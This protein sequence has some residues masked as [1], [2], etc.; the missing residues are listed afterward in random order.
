MGGYILGDKSMASAWVESRQ[1]IWNVTSAK[2]EV[3]PS[4]RRKLEIISY[5][6]LHGLNIFVHRTKWR[7]HK[8][9][10]KS[11]YSNW[12]VEIEKSLL[13]FVW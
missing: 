4:W 1:S 13:Y 2:D 6:K 8:S 3:A 12:V 10:C 5:P 9:G 7:R 11:S